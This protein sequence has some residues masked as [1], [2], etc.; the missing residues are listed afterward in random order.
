MADDWVELLLQGLPP[1]ARL[2][3]EP[4]RDELLAYARRLV[5]WRLEGRLAGPKAATASAGEAAR[6]PSAELAS[7]SEARKATQGTRSTSVTLADVGAL[8]P[9]FAITPEMF[10]RFSRLTGMD[11]TFLVGTPEHRSDLLLTMAVFS[12][13][14]GDGDPSDL[15]MQRLLKKLRLCRDQFRRQVAELFADRPLARHAAGV[16]AGLGRAASDGVARRRCL[17][18]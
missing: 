15:E 7:H 1:T 14:T 12:L 17:G 9:R 5:Q 4:V 13:L 18:V 6:A 2:R 8:A 16:L 11:S 10:Q 3:R